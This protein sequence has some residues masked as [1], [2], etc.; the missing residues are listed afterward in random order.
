M[1]R[2]SKLLQELK[3]MPDDAPRYVTHGEDTTTGA[4]ERLQKAVARGEFA[5]MSSAIIVKGK[6]ALAALPGIR[7]EAKA[8]N[9]RLNDMVKSIAAD[10][11]ETTEEFR[12]AE[13]GAEHKA[14]VARFDELQRKFTAAVQAGRMDA[15]SAATLEARLNQHANK[16]AFA[17]RQIAG[18]GA[19]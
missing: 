14:A 19:K 17:G 5:A 7:A 6:K 16:L 8:S 18:G 3:F 12:K 15:I 13:A 1:G 9:A 4:A 11:A 2:F 10:Q